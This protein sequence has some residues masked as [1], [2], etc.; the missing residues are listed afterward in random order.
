MKLNGNLVLNAGGQSEI[1]NAVLERVTGLPAVLAAEA[2]RILYNVTDGKY[3]YN[4]GSTW[5]A[6]ATGGNATH[7]QHIHQYNNGF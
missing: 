7:L 2:G 3:Y 4:T 5:M 6:F 1:Q